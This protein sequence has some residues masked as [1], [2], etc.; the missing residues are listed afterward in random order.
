MP[1]PPVSGPLVAE[2]TLAA[3]T[4][5][6]A[7]RTPLRVL[8]LAPQPFFQDRGTPIATRGLLAVLSARGYALEVLTY[9]EGDDVAI[10]NGR[11][12]RIPS[13]PGLR[14]IRPGF[15]FKKV[16][17]DAVM[18]VQCLAL[19]GTR[20]FQLVHALEES[21]F[22]ALIGRWLFRV[23]YVYDMDSS[24]ARQMEE[25]YPALQWVRGVMEYAESMAVRG[26]LATAAVCPALGAIAE[27]QA[28]D[29]MVSVIE[30]FSLLHDEEEPVESLAALIGRTGP[31][32]LYVGNLEIYQGIDLLLE[33]F[34]HAHA[35]RPDAELVVIGGHADDVARYR[36][37]CDKSGIGE[38]AHFLGPRPL[39]A[40]GGYLR[41]ATIVVSPRLLGQNTP[42][43]VYSYL[44]S[45]RPLLATRLETHTQVLD[46]DIAM[47]APAEPA[48]F[49]EA[50]ARREREATSRRGV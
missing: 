10:E 18:L 45:G 47:L 9:H 6:P 46:D 30:D 3:V 41:Q 25:K 21:V 36:Q 12:H 17:C 4:A 49:G 33:A 26:S 19:L 7:G 48:A 15:S 44:D 23:P 34:R 13:I 8:V 28:P 38:H 5:P 1:A 27:R 2:T 29:K 20:R 37:A 42:M 39:K 24:L 43:K 35:V 22:M 40:L 11:I 14:N 16:I 32:V 31:I 50:L